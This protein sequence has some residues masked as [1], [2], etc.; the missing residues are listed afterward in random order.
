MRRFWCG[1]LCVLLAGCAAEPKDWTRPDGQ[2]INPSQLQL[3]KTACEGEVEKAAVTG[4]ARSTV[5]MP[6]GMD[7]Q[8]MRV[9]TGCMASRGYLATANGN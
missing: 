7:R 1:L 9:F 8:D 5:G 2:P 3:D 6:F 4:Q